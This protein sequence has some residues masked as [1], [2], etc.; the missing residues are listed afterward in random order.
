MSS[1]VDSNQAPFHPNVQRVVDALAAHGITDR[2]RILDAATHTSQAAADYLGCDVAQIAKSI[3][4]RAMPSERCVLVI[5]SGKNRVSEDRIAA[6]LNEKLAKA[7]ADF[8]RDKTGFVI[9]GVAP[10]GHL[11]TPVAF[12]DADLCEYSQLWA[13]AGLPNT[14]FH[15]TP[16][17]LQRIVP[18]RVMQV[19]P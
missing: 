4:F 15:L 13:A 2:V 1:P 3:V 7:N 11:E 16:A 6:V 18:G 17:E 19:A 12:I 10:L 14:L 9:G 5:T 8:V